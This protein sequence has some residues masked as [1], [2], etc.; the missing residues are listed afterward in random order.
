MTLMTAMLA[1]GQ[2]N[3]LKWPCLQQDPYSLGLHNAFKRDQF[4]RITGIKKITFALSKRHPT[5]ATWKVVGMQWHKPL[6]C[7]TRAS[8]NVKLLQMSAKPIE[9][10]TTDLHVSHILPG[11]EY[12][13]EVIMG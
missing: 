13:G 8:I 5:K 9:L 6:S 4:R 2:T 7:L 10:L 1:K 12:W 11:K 3:E